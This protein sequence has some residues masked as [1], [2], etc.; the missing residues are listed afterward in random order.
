MQIRVANNIKLSY[1][2]VFK[3]IQILKEKNTNQ[4]RS[5]KNTRSERSNSPKI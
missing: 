1:V 2:S 5:F 3:Q 4:E